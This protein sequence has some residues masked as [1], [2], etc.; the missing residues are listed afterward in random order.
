MVHN[1]YSKQQ[2]IGG[3]NGKH[4]VIMTSTR[5]TTCVCLYTKHVFIINIM[6][7]KK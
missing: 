3:V 6:L 7:K 5:I 1:I 2:I 4:V